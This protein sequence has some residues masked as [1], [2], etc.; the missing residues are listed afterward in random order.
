VA[1]RAYAVHGAY[2]RHARALDERHS[3]AG[4]AP[5]ASRL[6][7]YGPLV[8]GA[9]FG[10]YAEASEDVH[11]MISFAADEAARRGWRRMGARTQAEAR[12][13]FVAS[14]RRRLGVHVARAYARH[15]LQRVPFIGVS[16]D[17]VQARTRRGAPGLGGGAGD[18]QEQFEDFFAFQAHMPDGAGD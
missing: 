8:H 11:L 13:F 5:I 18:E 4:T 2:V 15:R 9:V 3:A 14:Y 1:Q 12:A 10:Q 17:V 6:R 16:H 7:Q